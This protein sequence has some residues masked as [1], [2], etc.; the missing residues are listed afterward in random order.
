[1][2][3]TLN[4]SLCSTQ[5]KEPK[6]DKLGWLYHSQSRCII[7]C[8]IHYPLEQSKKDQNCKLQF[9]WADYI[10]RHSLDFRAVFFNH[11]PFSV[12]EISK[13][14]QV[15]KQK[16]K[17][18]ISTTSFGTNEQVLCYTFFGEVLPF[19][20]NLIFL[21]HIKWKKTY[22]KWEKARKPFS[23]GRNWADFLPRYHVT[24]LI[25]EHVSDFR[26]GP[27][28]SLHSTPILNLPWFV[29][30]LLVQVWERPL[31][32]SGA[33]HLDSS[34]LDHHCD[35]DIGEHIGLVDHP[36]AQDHVERPQL[37]PAQPHHRR[38][39]HGCPQLRPKV[40]LSDKTSVQQVW[41]K[42]YQLLRTK[43]S[44]FFQ[45]PVYERPSLAFR[46]NLLLSQ[47]FHLL[48]YCVSKVVEILSQNSDVTFF[49]ERKRMLVSLA[50]GNPIICCYVV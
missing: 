16:L 12:C 26:F 21:R 9:P 29:F 17:I 34:L 18:S 44:N 37:L 2:I 15:N 3:C 20:R 27:C 33:S 5:K 38:P 19:L 47:Q 30:K 45:L 24:V 31:L 40:L 39:A 36:G 7:L 4:L 23:S 50:I 1:M 8:S 13:K 28:S 14:K 43:I 25:S 32:E 10:P 46:G 11:G 49:F 35:L 6:H 41:T 22:L 42:F 48:P